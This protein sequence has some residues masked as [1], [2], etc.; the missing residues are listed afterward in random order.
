MEICVHS[1]NTFISTN[2]I[3]KVALGLVAFMLTLIKRM[4]H[5]KVSPES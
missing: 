2:A 3:I 1:L 5:D 4:H